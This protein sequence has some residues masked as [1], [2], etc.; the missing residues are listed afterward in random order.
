MDSHPRQGELYSALYVD[1]TVGI[2]PGY[3]DSELRM[4][5]GVVEAGIVVSARVESGVDR[6]AGCVLVVRFE[7]VGEDFGEMV[8]GLGAT[9]FL[10]ARQLVHEVFSTEP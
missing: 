10:I 7:S 2:G 1:Y 4:C 3:A 9:Q 6:V 8:R 5:A